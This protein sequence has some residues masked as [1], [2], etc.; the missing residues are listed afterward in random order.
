MKNGRDRLMPHG[1]ASRPH[2]RLTR[3]KLQPR[4]QRVGVVRATSY[5]P[6]LHR[7]AMFI[8]PETTSNLPSY[9][10]CHDSD[11]GGYLSILLAFPA[12]T[13]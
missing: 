8:S 5:L 13:H 10:P 12:L 11:R 4:K 3:L 7:N 2:V 6:A 9:S 1:S